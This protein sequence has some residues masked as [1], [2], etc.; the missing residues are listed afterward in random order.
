ML[1]SYAAAHHADGGFESANV[2]SIAID[3]QTAGYDGTRGP[4]AI[5]RLLDAFAT[6]PAFEHATP[7]D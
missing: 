3:L 7:G 6:E 1:R 5:T 4:V 2:T